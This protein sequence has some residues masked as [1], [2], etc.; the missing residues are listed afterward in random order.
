MTEAEVIA[1]IVHREGG[2]SDHPDDRGGPTKYGITVATLGRWRKYGRNA[3]R[4]EL[5]TL[6]SQEAGEIYHAEYITRPGFAQIAFE[7]LRVQCVDFGVNSGPP[8]A[9]RW[10]QRVCSCTPVDGVLG[11]VTARHVNAL[12]GRLVNDALVAARLRL[13]EDFMA[14]DP[15]QETFRRGWTTRALSFVLAASDGG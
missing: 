13:L 7:P 12:P 10:L 3:T 1:S 6:T 11:A 4:S 14:S 2:W 15:R 8:R 5:R 9:I